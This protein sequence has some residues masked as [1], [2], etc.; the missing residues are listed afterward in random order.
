MFP[1]DPTVWVSNEVGIPRDLVRNTVTLLPYTILAER[2]LK[3]AGRRVMDSCAVLWPVRQTTV[4]LSRLLIITLA[5]L[6]LP[7]KLNPVFD[8]EFIIEI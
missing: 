3:A 8:S 1:G 7:N 6:A 4:V 5:R 2:S